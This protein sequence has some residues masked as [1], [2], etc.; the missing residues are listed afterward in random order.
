MLHADRQ[1]VA[2]EFNQ[3]ISLLEE[4]KQQLVGLVRLELHCRVSR[5]DY[6]NQLD[7]IKWEHQH[8]DI[9]HLFLESMNQEASIGRQPQEWLAASEAYANVKLS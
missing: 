9:L 7:W 1:H 6:G 5:L 3:Y 4:A 8:G 2:T